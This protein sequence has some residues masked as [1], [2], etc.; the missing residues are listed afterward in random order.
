MRTILTEEELSLSAKLQDALAGSTFEAASRA[1][2][3]ARGVVSLAS[4]E[5]TINLRFRPTDQDSP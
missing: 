5:A 1:L 3:H 4:E 2:A